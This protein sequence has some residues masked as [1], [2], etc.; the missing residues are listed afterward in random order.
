M[1]VQ[2]HDYSK[3]LAADVRKRY[4]EKISKIDFIDPYLLNPTDLNYDSDVLP[5][6]SYPDH[7]HL[8][9]EFNYAHA[10]FFANFPK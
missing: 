8:P 2:L 5:Q 3:C 1:D 10:R 4:I 6:V 7:G 9:M